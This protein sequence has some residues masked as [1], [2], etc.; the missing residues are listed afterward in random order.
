VIHWIIEQIANEMEGGER[1]WE[2]VYRP[3]EPAISGNFET[4]QRRRK[5]VYAVVKYT[6][7][8]IITPDRRN[9]QMSER[10]GK[11]VDG[12]VKIAPK[13][14]ASEGEWKVINWVIK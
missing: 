14:K 6:N 7:Y 1:A 5:V 4:K 2:V 3:V 9:T 8:G 10:W 12:I 13:S 11:V